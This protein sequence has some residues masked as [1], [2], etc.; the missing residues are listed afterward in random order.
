MAKEGQRRTRGRHGRSGRLGV[1]ACSEGSDDGG[2]GLHPGSWEVLS[3][4]S[5]GCGMDP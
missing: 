2:G 1:D 3:A 4:L 5:W